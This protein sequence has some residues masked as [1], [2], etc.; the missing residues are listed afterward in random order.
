M[1]FG[2]SGPQMKRDILI[3]KWKMNSS[4]SKKRL[5]LALS[6][7]TYLL[8]LRCPVSAQLFI[9]NYQKSTIFLKVKTFRNNREFNP[10]KEIKT[11]LLIWTNLL[12]KLRVDQINLNHVL[13]KVLK[14]P[15]IKTTWK[16]TPMFMI[17]KI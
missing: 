2:D 7:E 4:F 17:L 15:L 9:N 10:K 1:L 13:D 5:L 6:K 12:C 8:I 14:I 3:Q 16:Q 11:L